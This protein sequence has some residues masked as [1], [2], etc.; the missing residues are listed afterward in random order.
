M[1]CNVE[2][3][4]VQIKVATTGHL[5]SHLY[6]DLQGNLLVIFKTLE[7]HYQPLRL[8]EKRPLLWRIQIV[9]IGINQTVIQST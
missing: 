2:S 4:S 8:M 9:I 7:K 6:T 3:V 5:S 1:D